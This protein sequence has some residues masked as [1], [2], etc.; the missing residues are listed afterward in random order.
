MKFE[1][2]QFETF[3]SISRA[4]NFIVAKDGTKFGALITAVPEYRGTD[5]N[6]ERCYFDKDDKKNKYG[7]GFCMEGE[8]RV[9]GNTWR[10]VDISTVYDWKGLEEALTKM[11][12]WVAPTKPKMRKFTVRFAV[13]DYLDKWSDIDFEDPWEDEYEITVDSI[14]KVMKANSVSE[15]EAIKMILWENIE[16]DHSRKDP[17][18]IIE[19]HLHENFDEYREEE[20]LYSLRFMSFEEEGGD[21]LKWGVDDEDWDD[22]YDESDHSDFY[23]DDDDEFD[24]DDDD[25][26]DDDEE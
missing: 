8:E 14:E 19:S 25:E 17:H 20:C 7:F 11:E 12:N 16:E 6:G 26:F 24:D 2:L 1:D 13:K 5:E 4:A 22:D 10:G 21:G 18:I 15:K 23:D 9:T 3:S